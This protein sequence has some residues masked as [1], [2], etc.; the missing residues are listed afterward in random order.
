M[1]TLTIHIMKTEELTFESWARNY[2][3]TRATDYNEEEEYRAG[4]RGEWERLLDETGGYIKHEESGIWC[5][6]EEIEEAL[7]Q[8]DTADFVV[9]KDEEGEVKHAGSI[10]NCLASRETVRINAA[11][12]AFEM[13]AGC[14]GTFLTEDQK[15]VYW[16]SLEKKLYRFSREE[17]EQAD[18]KGVLPFRPS[19]F[20][21]GKKY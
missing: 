17:R 14:A 16:Q 3:K 1:N 18:R 11:C 5:T 2:A 10:V 9:K 21:T 4:L 7:D 12:D 8:Y 6:D 19:L 15:T 13:D 20:R